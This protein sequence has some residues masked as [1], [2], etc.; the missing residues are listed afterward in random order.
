[1]IYGKLVFYPMQGREVGIT[2]WIFLPVHKLAVTVQVCPIVAAHGVFL[3][4]C[5]AVVVG[6]GM[7]RVAAQPW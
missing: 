2:R 3:F 6:V 4:V 5:S 1:M 7:P